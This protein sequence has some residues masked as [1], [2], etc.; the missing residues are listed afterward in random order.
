MSCKRRIIW[1]QLRKVHGKLHFNKAFLYKEES[2]DRQG[3]EG[4][5]RTVYIA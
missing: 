5:L 1:E 4:L 2:I 3:G